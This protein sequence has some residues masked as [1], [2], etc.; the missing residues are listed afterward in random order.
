MLPSKLATMRQE[1]EA[2]LKNDQ[3]SIDDKVSLLMLRQLEERHTND[4][5]SNELIKSLTV[6]RNICPCCGQKTNRL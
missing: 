3:L 2:L 4:K 5:N 1:L 6:A